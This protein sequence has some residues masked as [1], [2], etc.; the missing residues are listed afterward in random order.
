MCISVKGCVSAP[1]P[2]LC[3]TSLAQQKHLD[4]TSHSALGDPGSGQVKGIVPCIIYFYGGYEGEGHSSSRW[5]GRFPS[6]L[7]E[8]VARILRRAFLSHVE[9]SGSD[10][11]VQGTK[12]PARLA[13][14]QDYILG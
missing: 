12:S 13:N 10:M 9:M 1:P 7:S 6:M 8:H 14:K 5:I 3:Q 2:R 11:P 4:M